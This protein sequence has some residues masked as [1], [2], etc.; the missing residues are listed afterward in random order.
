MTYNSRGRSRCELLAEHTGVDPAAF[1]SGAN[2]VAQLD[3]I[4]AAPASRLWRRSPQSLPE[5]HPVSRL[6]FDA[7]QP[8]DAG[9]IMRELTEAE[10]ADEH[11]WLARGLSAIERALGK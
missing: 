1:R 3:Q 6:A 5:P 7:E 10:R 4:A 8:L 2:L 11:P 9:K